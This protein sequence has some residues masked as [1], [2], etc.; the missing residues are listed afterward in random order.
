MT[1]N[2]GLMTTVNCI[3]IT[4]YARGRQQSPRKYMEMIVFVH[5]CD[6]PQEFALTEWI[7]FRWLTVTALVV[8]NC[9][10]N[11]KHET[12]LE[13]N[14]GFINKFIY[15]PMLLSTRW[16]IC[17]LPLGGTFDTVQ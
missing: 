17:L 13:F 2:L 4:L 11:S 14:T 6:K 3:I 9:T 8:V 1:K 5:S 12:A 15:S 7:N 10:W 16:N